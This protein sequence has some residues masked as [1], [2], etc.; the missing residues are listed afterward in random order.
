MKIIPHLLSGAAGPFGDC[1][2]PTCLAPPVL[3]LCKHQSG[4]RSRATLC[5]NGVHMNSQ[6]TLAG[7][8]TGGL[9]TH[10][11]LHPHH[12]R[13]RPLL[14]QQPFPAPL[15]SLPF[16]LRDFKCRA[17]PP[18]WH[19]A[20]SGG[21]EA[22]SAA[23]RC[24]ECGR[25]NACPPFTATPPCVAWHPRAKPSPRKRKRVS[26]GMEHGACKAPG[27]DCVCLHPL[28]CTLVYLPCPTPITLRSNSSRP[29]AIF[30]VPGCPELP[31]GVYSSTV[32]LPQ[33]KFDM[34]ANSVV[35]EPQLQQFWEDNKIY[36]Q[37]S[38]NNPGVSCN[39]RTEGWVG[40]VEQ[41]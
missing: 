8:F 33:T 18:P 35:R 2:N 12:V 23:A 11:S 20:S 32:N 34:R 25:R 4:H 40:N 14:M 29:T 17:T 13:M 31:A 5:A 9:P 30:G 28:Y 19:Y 39:G 10:C 1:I 26:T 3:G 21:W 16:S 37:L 27:R 38:R 15:K 6:G 24:V 41:H 22:T 36:E 7:A